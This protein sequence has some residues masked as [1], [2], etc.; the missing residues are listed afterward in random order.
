MFLDVYVLEILRFET[1]TF[2]NSYVLWCYVK[3]HKRCVMLRFVALWLIQYFWVRRW[4][5]VPCV[6]VYSRRP[7]RLDRRPGS[8]GRT[9]THRSAAHRSPPR[10]TPRSRTR[11]TPAPPTTRVV[12]IKS[13]VHIFFSTTGWE[14]C[15]ISYSQNFAHIVSIE[16]NIVFHENHI[17]GVIHFFEKINI[18]SF[19]ES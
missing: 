12:K 3:W 13:F 8:R 2:R 1:L 16:E 6:M 15:G 18:F 19:C 17:Y 9:G 10:R 7:D 4:E 11:S 5:G 14:N